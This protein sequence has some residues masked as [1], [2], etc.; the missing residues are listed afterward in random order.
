VL[1]AVEG[2]P[3]RSSDCWHIVSILQMLS[4]VE[5]SNLESE[6]FEEAL[7]PLKI[8]SLIQFNCSLTLFNDKRIPT[9]GALAVRKLLTRIMPHPIR[10][11]LLEIQLEEGLFII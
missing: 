8:I 6:V 3:R 1:A 9:L 5:F 2:Q 4:G 10:N 11:S 7:L